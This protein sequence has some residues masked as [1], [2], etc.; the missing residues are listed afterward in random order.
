MTF[1]QLIEEYYNRF[2]LYG[3]EE[4]M[5]W[6]DDMLYTHDARSAV[7]DFVLRSMQQAEELL[8]SGDLTEEYIAEAEEDHLKNTKKNN[9]IH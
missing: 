2:L 5:K 8:R 4:A 6:L 9:N 3:Q 1:E 7:K